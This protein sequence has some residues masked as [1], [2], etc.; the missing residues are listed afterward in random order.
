VDGGLTKYISSISKKKKKRKN[1][2]VPQCSGKGEKRVKAD[3][4]ETRADLRGKKRKMQSQGKMEPLTP[5]DGGERSHPKRRAFVFLEGGGGKFLWS[6]RSV[7]K[8]F[9]IRNIA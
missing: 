3:K 5:L 6:L 2:I 7:G 4:R 1:T 8:L 9:L